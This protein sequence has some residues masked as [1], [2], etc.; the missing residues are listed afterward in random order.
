MSTIVGQLLAIVAIAIVEIG[1]HR[2][3]LVQYWQGYVA[4]ILVYNGTVSDS[5]RQTMQ[6]YLAWKWG[7]QNNLP[8]SHPYKSSPPKNTYGTISN[9]VIITIAY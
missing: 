8:A 2:Q 5:D 3:K 7:M 4:E 1:G 9:I 6:G